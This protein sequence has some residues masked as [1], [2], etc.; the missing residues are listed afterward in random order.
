M[1]VLVTCLLMKLTTIDRHKIKSFVK[2]D[3][4]DKAMESSPVVQYGGQP[5]PGF[6]FAYTPTPASTG[7]GNIP[8]GCRLRPPPDTASNCHVQAMT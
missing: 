6:S 3:R 4:T 8:P 2:N 7:L 5:G 1:L